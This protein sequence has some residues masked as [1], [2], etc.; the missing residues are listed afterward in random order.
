MTDHVNENLR[1]LREK[2]GSG[3]LFGEG[4]VDR[5]EVDGVEFVCQY[6]S[7]STADRFFLVKPAP[8][9]AAF[10][11][12]IERFR[13]GTI[14][15]LGIAEGGST[16]LLALSAAPRRL[17]A[18]DLEPTR[19]AALDELVARR[20]LE[21]VVVAHYGVDQGDGERLA[22]LV[23]E[24]RQ[25]E[26]L[27]A[28]IDDASHDLELTTASFDVLFPRLRPGGTYIVEDWHNDLAFRAAVVDALRA[29]DDPSVRD[30]LRRSIQ[31]AAAEPGGGPTWP[32]PLFDLAVRL[33][34]A[35]AVDP[36]A[37]IAEVRLT[38]YWIEVVRSDQPLDPVGYHLVDHAPDLY[39]H[40]R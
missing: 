11:R 10:R 19:L 18:F 6:E 34:I 37:G 24:G 5:F 38:P 32:R 17:L 4:D 31:A 40:L 13:G 1:Q 16:A 26:P 20:G 12:S 28:V 22:R 7:G 21:D 27:D 9:A 25:G 14:V 35:V 39:G 33:G 23:D 30:E 3:A 2:F 8:F 15:E 36:G 29:T